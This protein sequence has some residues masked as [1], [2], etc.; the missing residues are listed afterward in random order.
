M[1][2]AFHLV[3]TNFRFVAN[4]PSFS[5]ANKQTLQSLGLCFPS[6]TDPLVI[7]KVLATT[8]LHRVFEA[9]NF[10]PTIDAILNELQKKPVAFDPLATQIFEGVG[11]NPML[12][13]LLS[14]VRQKN[15][16]SPESL[17]NALIANDEQREFMVHYICILE[18]ITRL[19]MADTQFFGHVMDRLLSLTASISNAHHRSTWQTIYYA[20]R[21]G[22]DFFLAIKSASLDPWIWFERCEREHAHQATQEQKKEFIK[23]HALSGQIPAMVRKAMHPTPYDLRGLRLN[24]AEASA[25]QAVD[26]RNAAAGFG[27]IAYLEKLIHVN[28]LREIGQPFPPENEIKPKNDDFWK[29]VYGYKKSGNT[30]AGVG[31]MPKHWNDLYSS[32]NMAYIVANHPP[33]L[34]FLLSKLLIPTV[35][36]ADGP[37]YIVARVMA[38][39]VALFSK[40]IFDKNNYDPTKLNTPADAT[41]KREDLVRLWAEVNLEKGSGYAQT[42]KDA[43]Q[44]EVAEQLPSLR[45]PK[46]YYHLSMLMWNGRDMHDHSQDNNKGSSA[47]QKK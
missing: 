18:V 9:Q 2:T 7:K 36:N 40:E 17:K 5:L 20:W 29:R 3:P 22:K 38:L 42:S 23:S 30:V 1:S 13:T 25:N 10:D 11:E 24:I 21:H 12:T 31:G 27:L 32:W 47:N 15:I 6:H 26:R 19:M 34:Q 4:I 28:A 8:G 41:K 43:L 35:L 33:H 39:W 37:T 14:R 46:M 45:N 16:A 44:K